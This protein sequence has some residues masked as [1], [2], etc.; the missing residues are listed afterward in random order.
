MADLADLA[1]DVVEQAIQAGIAKALQAEKPSPEC[2]D[3]GETI[4]KKRREAVPFARRCFDCQTI[5][6]TWG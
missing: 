1:Q 2:V 5:K 4:S 3:C 6:E